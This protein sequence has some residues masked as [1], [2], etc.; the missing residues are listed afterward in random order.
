MHPVDWKPHPEPTFG[1]LREYGLGF[2]VTC[3]R[4]GHTCLISYKA[5]RFL[6]ERLPDEM[7]LSNV[8]ESFRCQHCNGNRVRIMAEGFSHKR[9]DEGRQ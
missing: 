2:V 5:S 6:R 9:L 7:R 4:C 3:K 8:G 1:S